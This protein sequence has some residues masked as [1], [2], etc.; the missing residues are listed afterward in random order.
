MPT[1]VG[2]SPTG[3]YLTSESEIRLLLLREGGIVGYTDFVTRCLGY[4]TVVQPDDPSKD[5]NVPS[6]G[7]L[8]RNRV[9]SRL[10]AVALMVAAPRTRARVVVSMMFGSDRVPSARLLR[11]A[12]MDDAP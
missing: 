10:I 6:M 7:P 2:S 9:S 4:Q 3:R 8:L 5:G 12:G 1:M 11:Q